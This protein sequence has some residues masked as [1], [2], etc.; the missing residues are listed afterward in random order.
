MIRRIGFLLLKKTATARPGDFLGTRQAGFM[1]LRMANLADIKL[2][3]KARKI[4]ENIY[5]RD[6]DLRLPENQLLRQAV[7]QFWPSLAGTGDVS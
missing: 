6:P 3:A 7:Y 4:A 5:E 2:I 1:D